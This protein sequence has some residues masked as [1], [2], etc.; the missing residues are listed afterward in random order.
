MTSYFNRSIA[1]MF[2]DHNCA[3]YYLYPG[4]IEVENNKKWCQRVRKRSKNSRN[5][6]ELLKVAVVENFESFSLF[7]PHRKLEM[8]SNAAKFSFSFHTT[9]RFCFISIADFI[10]R[11]WKLFFVCHWKLLMVFWG[12]QN[13]RSSVAARHVALTDQKVCLISIES[14]SR[15]GGDDLWKLT[16]K[17]AI[18]FMACVS[19]ETVVNF[20]NLINSPLKKTSICRHSQRI[21]F[22]FLF[23]I[24]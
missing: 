8:L 2:I 3:D 22:V 17:T 4:V 15:Q 24:I 13:T 12:S 9:P 20:G 11:T 1:C 23:R 7:S 21:L 18:D 5:G 14:T 19:P 6:V 16:R 10:S